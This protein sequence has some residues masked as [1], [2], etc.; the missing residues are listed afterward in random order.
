MP[1]TKQWQIEL[2]LPNGVVLDM[3]IDG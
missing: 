2:R 3:S 1:D